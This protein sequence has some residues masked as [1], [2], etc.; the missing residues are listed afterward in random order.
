[1]NKEEVL[2]R[3]RSSEIQLRPSQDRVSFP[4]ILRIHQKM[5]IGLTFDSIQVAENSIIVNGHHR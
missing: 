2:A 5:K 4:V 1:M 3:M